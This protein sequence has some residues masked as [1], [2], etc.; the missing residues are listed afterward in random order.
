M[1]YWKD[2]NQNFI[3]LWYTQKVEQKYDDKLRD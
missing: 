1:H 3:S 2:A